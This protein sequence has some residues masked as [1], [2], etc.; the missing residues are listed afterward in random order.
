MATGIVDLQTLV[1]P[2]KVSSM[3]S[4]V[5]CTMSA[6][7]PQQVETRR[8][9]G[10]DHS[11]GRSAGGKGMNRDFIAGRRETSYTHFK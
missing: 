4:Q 7:S 1:S 8:D 5:S 3:I 10:P 2:G 6:I 9:R 11:L